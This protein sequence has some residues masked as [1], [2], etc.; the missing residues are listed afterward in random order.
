MTIHTELAEASPPRDT[1]V[2]IGTFDGVH[3]GHQHLL[4]RLNELA[5]AGGYMSAALS[6]RNHPK[7]VLVPGVNLGYITPLEERLSLIRQ[8]GTGLVV[9]V[10]FTRELSL[11][12]AEEF[13]ELLVRYL[14]MKCLLVGPDFA[15][16]HRREG[17]IPT[18]RLL[19]ART[20]VAVEVVEPV[21]GNRGVI[22]SSEVRGFIT[23]GDVEGASEMLG[24]WY[25][26]TG[27]VVQGDRRGREL[28]F[29]TANLAIDQ[30]LATPADGI[31][32][33]WATVDG[34]RHP[35]ATSIGLRPTFGVSGRTVEAFIM[36][37]DEDI[38]G[39][40]VTLEFAARL[41]D[42]QAF[43]DAEA[44]VRQMNLDVDQAREVLASSPEVYAKEAGLK[45][46]PEL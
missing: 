33:T 9:P 23:R 14:R 27:V 35:A 15:L 8:Q 45:A 17:D 40:T 18:L 6:F 36:D 10:E 22:R 16:G 4:R 32:A 26:L 13:V 1:V 34:R 2:T 28:G 30:S 19:G 46:R 5:A 24:R 12:K 41:R 38:Y 44:L 7:T 37:F 42:E 43:Q 3:L 29:P 31:Y 21:S 39:K 20:G 11:L 25:S